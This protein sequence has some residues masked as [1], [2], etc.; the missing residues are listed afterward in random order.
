MEVEEKKEGVE[1]E[2]EGVGEEGVGKEGGV[3][4]HTPGTSSCARPHLHGRLVHLVLRSTAGEPSV[5][6]HCSNR[7]RRFWCSCCRRGKDRCLSLQ[8]GQGGDTGRRAGGLGYEVILVCCR[9]WGG[10]A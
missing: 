8:E 5:S 4:V 3:Q 7:R 10:A 2:E 1:E 6:T 9:L